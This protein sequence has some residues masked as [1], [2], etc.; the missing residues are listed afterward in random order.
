MS[1][2]LKQK[3]QEHFDITSIEAEDLI[4]YATPLGLKFNALSKSFKTEH[5]VALR[6]ATLKERKEKSGK[7]R[8][9]SRAVFKSVFRSPE[10]KQLETDFK[11]ARQA[12]LLL[13]EALRAHKI[14]ADHERSITEILEVMSDCGEIQNVERTITGRH[15]YDTMLEAGLA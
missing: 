14:K 3:L 1:K 2:E 11:E 13:D 6:D 9:L 12:R 5:F 4:R 7:G 15:A 8:K 10:I